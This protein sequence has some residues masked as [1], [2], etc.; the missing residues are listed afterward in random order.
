MKVIVDSPEFP[1]ELLRGLDSVAEE[2]PEMSSELYVEAVKKIE[3]EPYLANTKNEKPAQGAKE[4]RKPE[5]QGQL[6]RKFNQGY[7]K[8]HNKLTELQCDNVIRIPGDC[9]HGLKGS[10]TNRRYS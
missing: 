9:W 6:G 5:L 8:M 7:Y 2:F 1:D 4:W 10:A 3:Y